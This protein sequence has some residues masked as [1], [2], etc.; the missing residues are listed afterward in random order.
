[1]LMQNC[2]TGSQLRKAISH[3]F[4][5]NKMCTR[6]I[7]DNVWVHYCRKHYQRVRYR[8]VQKYAELQ[9]DM[10]MKQVLRVQAWSRQNVAQDKAGQL[11]AWQLMARKR[12]QQRLENEAS[13]KGAGC[14]RT[15]SQRIAGDHINGN[16]ADAWAEP[17]PERKKGSTMP[18][19][20]PP[21]LQ[22]KCGQMYQTDQVLEILREIEL[23]I[24][25]EEL[26]QIPDI[27]LL[28]QLTTDPAEE[29][30]QK[31]KRR[32]QTIFAPHSRTPSFEMNPSGGGNG[33]RHHTGY[34][35]AAYAPSGDNGFRSQTGYPNTAYAPTGDNGFRS[36]AVY[37]SSGGNGFQSQTGYPNTAYPPSG[38]NGFRTHT[39]FPEPV[40]PSGGGN[41]FQSQ[42]GYSEAAYPSGGD[43]GFRHHTG[44]MDV[45][46]SS[47]GDNGF[48]HHTGY[49]DVAHPSGGDNGF[50][51]HTGYSDVAHPSGGD[52]GFKH[53]TGYS[54]VAHT[55]GG[56]NGFRHH[57]DFPEAAY[58]S[59][60]GNGVRHHTGYPDPA[61]LPSGNNGFR[62]HAGY[63]DAAYPPWRI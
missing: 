15:H 37:P 43:N 2:T 26:Q 46:H 63:S 59:G 23:R 52:N 53:H 35:D 50:K 20:V 38:D 47:G 33:I 49:S 13:P 51:H 31:Y 1:M 44:Y 58:P 8:N 17:E 41:V 34:P 5:R 7:P 6:Q 19:A 36:H 25:T 11:T 60:G 62:H 12:E 30:R 56:D 54:D 22:A 42:T 24:K 61:R 28:P 10:V 21:W 3:I 18:N 39:R 32:S 29:S 45:A 14:K 57:T 55:S 9:I 40:Y 16:A 27:E 48:R 4:G